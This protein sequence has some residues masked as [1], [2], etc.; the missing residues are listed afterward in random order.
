VREEALQRNGR[1]LLAG[2][3]VEPLEE[4]LVGLGAHRCAED[5]MIIVEGKEA[6]QEEEAEAEP[7]ADPVSLQVEGSVAHREPLPKPT[8]T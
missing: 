2:L 8:G 1:H 6:P 3:W 7:L 5:S 4:H